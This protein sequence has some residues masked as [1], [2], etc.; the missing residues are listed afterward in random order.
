MTDKTQEV[1]QRD[2]ITLFFPANS[3][4][5]ARFSLVNS[6]SA[7]GYLLEQIT[8]LHLDAEP[9]SLTSPTLAGGFFTTRAS[10]EALSLKKKHQT[11]K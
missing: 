11:P 6:I 1:S 2:R 8:L 7:P 4:N 5:P 10:W 3:K 9:A